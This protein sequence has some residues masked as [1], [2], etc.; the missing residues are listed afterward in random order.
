VE[1]I[2]LT[3][4]NWAPDPDTLFQYFSGWHLLVAAGLILVIMALAFR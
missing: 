1:Y 4:S 2:L 3:L